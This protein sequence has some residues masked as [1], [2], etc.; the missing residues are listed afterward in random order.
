M[1]KTINIMINKYIIIFSKLLILKHPYFI[2]TKLY[3]KKI[4]LTIGRIIKITG[5]HLNADITSNL[6]ANKNRSVTP[7]PGH[8]YPVISLK[9]HGIL[10]F[11]VKHKI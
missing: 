8:L 9:K 10:K 7:H 11:V 1:P 4:I 2:Y 5:L 6:K 3:L